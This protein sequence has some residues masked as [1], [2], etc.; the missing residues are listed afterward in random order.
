MHQHDNNICTPL[1]RPWLQQVLAKGALRF[2]PF[3]IPVSFCTL[4]SLAPI[5]NVLPKKQVT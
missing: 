4:K 5:L 1:C 3:V 2:A